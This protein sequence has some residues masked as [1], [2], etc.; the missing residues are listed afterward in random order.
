MVLDGDEGPPALNVK[1]GLIHSSVAVFELICLRA[2]GERRELM[3]E[4]DPENRKLSEKLFDL[5]DLKAVL[6]RIA[7]AVAEHKAVKRTVKYLFGGCIVREDSDVAAPFEKLSDDVHFRPVIDE[8][9][10]E[11]RVFGLEKHFLF[12]GNAFHGVGDSVFAY[13]IEIGAFA[14]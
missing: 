9:D 3:T 13:L 1:N 2:D 12:A 6:A 4:A 5:V 10:G 7:G 8:S 11:R 14:E